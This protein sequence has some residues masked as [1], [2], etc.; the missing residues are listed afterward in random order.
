M[1]VLQINTSISS[2][3]TGR[4]ASDIGEI[5]IKEGHTSVIAYGRTM[6]ESS[7]IAI[8]IGNKKDF[9]LHLVNTRFFDKHGFSS[10]QATKTF[11]DC[12]KEINPDIIHL[13]NIHGYYLHVG[14]LFD[15]LKKSK[16]PIVWTF[17]DCWP[18]TGHCSYFDRFNCYRWQSECFNCPN[19]HGYPESWFLDNSRKNFQQKKELFSGLANMT[20]ISPSDWMADHINSSFMNRYPVKI[21]KNGVDL[22]KFKPS[23]PA[24]V[25]EKYELKG[26]YIIL[27]VANIW[28]KR[29][30]LTDFIRLRS[31]LDSC[32]TIVLVGL[33]SKQIRN[34]PE[35]IRGLTRTDSIEELAALYSAADVFVNPTYVDNFPLVNLEALA[36]GTPVVTYNTGGSPEAG[37]NSETGRVFQKGDVE[38]LKNGILDLIERSKETNTILSRNR[39]SQLFNCR[40]RYMDYISTYKEI[41]V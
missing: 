23:D 31:L 13:H 33:K 34:L 25:K 38:N 24:A 21:I 1:K 19:K 26:K 5:L 7:S 8:K 40:D 36:C 27:G 16:K 41:S 17:H 22:D 30:G 39:A 2:G 32:F 29:K 35:G 14:V 11:I 9:L 12:I 28:D 3:S 18:F 37:G 20:L 15:Y 10:K 4:I 6:R